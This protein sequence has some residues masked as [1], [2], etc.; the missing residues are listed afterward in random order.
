MAT[1]E[2]VEYQRDGQIVTLRLNRPQKLNAFNDEMVVA[3]QGRF[4][5]FDADPDANVAIL[6]GN[7]R[8]FSTGARGVP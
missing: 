1:D 5:Q 3:L 4:R 7:G 6:C 8:A 2:L